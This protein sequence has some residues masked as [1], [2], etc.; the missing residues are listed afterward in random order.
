[1]NPLLIGGIAGAGAGGILLFLSHIA[2]RFGAGVFVHDTDQPRVFGH[3][4]SRREAHLVGIMLHM[5]LSFLF[6][7]FYVFCAD[8]NVFPAEGLMVGYGALSLAVYAALMTLF[9]GGVVLPIEGHGLFGLR[10]D[11]WFPVDLII[12]NILWA[13]LFGIAVRLWM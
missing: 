5:A 4:I 12:T 1:M 13:A 2:P 3:E 7:A 8:Y 11:S 9:M 10:E 6:G